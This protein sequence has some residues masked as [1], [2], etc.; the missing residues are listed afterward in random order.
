MKYFSQRDPRWANVKL[1]ASNIDVYHYG[2]T[3]TCISMLSDYF[4]CLSYPDAIAKV[5]T[6]YTADG[7]ILWSNLKFT[8]MA[9]V[10]RQYGRNDS[11]IRTS[12]KNPDTAVILQVNDG[13]HWVVALRPTVFGNDYVCLDPWT[14]KKCDVIKTYK[15]ITGSAH[16]TRKK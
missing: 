14:G 12:L 15:N 9:F 1:G 13:K 3:T 8:K 16:F 5:K 11:L 4:G 10:W 6:N 7:L 2:C